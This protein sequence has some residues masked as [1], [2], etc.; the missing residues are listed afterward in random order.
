MSNKSYYM[1]L[2]FFNQPVEINKNSV[3]QSNVGYFRINI[4]CTSASGKQVY[5]ADDRYS[6]VDWSKYI[7]IVSIKDLNSDLLTRRRSEGYEKEHNVDNIVLN[8]IQ[9]TLNQCEVD[10][11]KLLTTRLDYINNALSFIVSQETK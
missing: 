11:V 8:D 2:T 4:Y 1:T 6:V 9:H 3:T 10:T 5:Q 7:Y